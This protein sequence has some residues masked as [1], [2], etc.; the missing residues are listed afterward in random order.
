MR[1][2]SILAT[3]IAQKLPITKEYIL[4]EY[5]DVFSVIGTLPGAEYHITLKKGYI[6]VQHPQRLFP[7]KCKSVYIED[8]QQLCNEGTVTTV[9]EHTEWINS[10]IPVRKENGSLRLSFDPKDLNRKI[11]MNQYYTRTINYLSAELLRFKYFTL[12]DAKSGYLTV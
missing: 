4:K 12:M 6:P 2:H 11:Q 8:L 1:W 3:Y 7:V 9:Q 5:H 10:I